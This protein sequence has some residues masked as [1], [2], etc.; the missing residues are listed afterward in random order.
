VAYLGAEEVW[1]AAGTYRTSATGDRRRSFRLRDGLALYGGFAG[2]EERREQRD[3]KANESTLSGDLG[4]PLGADGNALHVVL[5]ADGAV[6]DGFTIADGCADV[7]AV[8]GHGAGLLCYNAVS[9]A[10]RNCRFTRLRARDSGAVY[11]YNLSSP[12]FEVCEFIGCH[13]ESGG[14]AG[15]RVGSC[16]GFS[17]CRFIGNSAR[18]RAGAVQIDDGSGPSFTSCVFESCASGGHGGALFLESVAAQIGV[19]GT[20]VEEC[21]FLGNSAA[22]RGGAVGAAD[23]S[24]PLIAGCTFAANRAGAGGG[25]ISADERVTVTLSSCTFAGND[26]GSGEPDIDADERSRVV[27]S[28]TTPGPSAG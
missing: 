26:G 6:R 16:P 9:P 11:A 23:A 5:G 4:S 24:E 28:S 3:W 8:D 19:I 14:A 13:A 25:A 17:D 21:T 12:S 18:W 27:R 20:T 2:T 10:V 15:A 1:V 7:M 22:L